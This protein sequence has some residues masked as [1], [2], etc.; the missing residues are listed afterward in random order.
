MSKIILFYKYVNIETPH[1]TMNW[2]RELCESLNLKGRIILATEGINAT[3]GGTVK[4]IEAYIAAMNAHPLFGNIDYKYSSGGAEYFP[5]LR[6]VVKNEIVNLGI[7]PQDLTTENTG[8]HLTPKQTHELLQNKPKD[9]IILDGRN[10]YEAAVGKFEDAITP[11]IR[12]FRQFPDYI[13]QNLEQFKDKEVLMYCTGGIRCERASAYLKSKGIAK[14]VYQVEGGI[15]RY[16]EEYPDGFF[17]GKNYVFDARVTVKV[18]AEVLGNCFVC[19]AKCDDYMNC[20][21]AECNKHYIGCQDCVVRLNETCSEKCNI[22]VLE[23]R[24]H[25][26]PQFTKLDAVK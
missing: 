4:E 15:H 19:N 23:N 17:K 11:D 13:D 25:V 24:V 12:Y 7:N 26:R 16:V 8:K 22:L 6:I 3:L 2:Q 10:N 14:E 1:Q 9:L 18:N 5:R 21:N 20:R